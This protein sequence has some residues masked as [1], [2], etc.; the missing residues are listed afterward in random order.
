MNMWFSILLLG[1]MLVAGCAG[2]RDR[3][4][5]PAIRPGAPAN[6]QPNRKFRDAPQNVLVGR[7]LKINPAGR[8]VVLNFP[9]GRL[10][11]LDQRLGVYRQGLKIGEVKVSG[12]QLE[13]NVVAD[14]IAGEAQAGDQVRD[15]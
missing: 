15:R 13:E 11:T 4:A 7:I 9:P 3:T 14:L 10:P 2:K 8:F 6:S 5:Q 1:V 12:P